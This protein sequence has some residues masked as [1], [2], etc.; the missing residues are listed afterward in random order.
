MKL[1]LH[2]YQKQIRSQQE[3]KNLSDEYWHKIACK[4]NP[5]THYK[6]YCH[7]WVGFIPEIIQHT[8]NLLCKL[9]KGL[10]PHDYL[11]RHRKDFWQNSTS[12][13][14]NSPEECR[15]TGGKNLN[16]TKTTTSPQTTSCQT[17]KKLKAFPRKFGT[18]QGCPLSPLL[19]I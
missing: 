9:T 3:K 11:N 4:P 2:W 18:W 5:Q 14:E 8:C 12:L 15:N 7:N 6:H 17:E 16:I 13:H 1:F 10:K 19:F